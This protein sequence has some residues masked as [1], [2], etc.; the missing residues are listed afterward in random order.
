MAKEEL[1]EGIKQAIPRGETLERA[2]TTFF[3][4]GYPQEDIE[5]AAR[6]LQTPNF[7]QWLSQQPQQK[8]Q[9][10]QPQQPQQTSQYQDIQQQTPQQFQQQ[11]IQQQ[12][13]NNSYPYPPAVT[14]IVSDY[15]KKPSKT[16]A[17]ITI[18]LFFLLL[19]LFGI[20]AAVILF[21]DELSDFF[22]NLLLRALF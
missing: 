18:I 1:V 12:Q 19:I 13:L 7:S 22:T 5:E 17:V 15:N 3:N 6:V 4:A 8:K 11:Q 20:L 21:K 2:M 16:G 9:T 14:Q 10:Q